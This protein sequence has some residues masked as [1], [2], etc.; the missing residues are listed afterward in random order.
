MQMSS[1]MTKCL[2]IWTTFSR[3]AVYIYIYIYIYI[4]TLVF[5]NIEN[6]NIYEKYLNNYG[7]ARFI[8]FLS[9]PGPELL[10][11]DMFKAIP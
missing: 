1:L 3:I 2:F 11:K 9:S 8:Y 5:K 7:M 6:T 4:Y 10:E